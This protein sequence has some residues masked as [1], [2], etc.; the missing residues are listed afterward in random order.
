MTVV[1]PNGHLS[2]TTDYCDQ[3]GAP[4]A[5]VGETTEIL[6]VIDDADTSP[7]A[8]AEP[9]PRCATPRAGTDR[10]CEQ[11][12]FDFTAPPSAQIRWEA[13]VRADR[14]QSQRFGH[15]AASFP[16]DARERTYVLTAPVI[17]IGRTRGQGESPEAT[18]ELSGPPEDPGVSRRH[19]ALE[20][21][22][23]G[24]YG[25]QD[26]GSTNGTLLNDDP[27]PIIAGELVR[28]RDGDTI[29]LG[30]WTAIEIRAC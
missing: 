20:R 2:V 24:S 7:A 27:N 25:I 14:S 9:C 1:C 3:C 19:A 12:G 18:I 8:R 13:A 26:L 17:S 28:L 21:Q 5:G 30:A 15:G 11:C 4:I 10:F 16:E 23:D 29:R 6:S 22:P